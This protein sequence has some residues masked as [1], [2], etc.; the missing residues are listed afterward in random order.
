M[1]QSNVLSP[2]FGVT[3]ESIV[4]ALGYTPARFLKASGAAVA[5]TGTTSETILSYV[6][7]P[8]GTMGAN[9]AIEIDSVWSVVGSGG[10][11]NMIVRIVAGT[12]AGTTGGTAL[13]DSAV[14][15]ANNV[16]WNGLIVNANATNSQLLY[17]RALAAFNSSAT[18][19]GT[20]AVD[21]SAAFTISLN[22][23]LA[24]GADALTLRH[25]A[26]ILRPGV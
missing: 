26:A 4:A 22:G 3:A 19:L 13:M 7:V 1:P 25:F 20:A 18:A 12:S 6:N 2:P 17:P 14:T 5:L 11:W 16:R 10:V 8:A 9:S 23:K 24:A 15:A 21:T